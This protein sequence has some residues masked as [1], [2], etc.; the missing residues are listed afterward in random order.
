MAVFGSYI[1]R[2]RSLFGEAIVVSTLD[3]SV[4]LCAGLIIFPACAAYGVSAEAGP[5]LIFVS[6]PVMFNHMATGQLWG[7]LFFVFMLFAAMSTVVA[8]FENIIASMRDIYTDWS[9]QKACVVNGIGIFVLAIPCALG[10]SVW[11]NFAPLGEGTIVLD[12]EDF[13]L[14]NNLLPIG[15]TIYLM[16]CMHRYGWGWGN[17]IKEVDTGTGYKFPKSLRVFFSYIAPVIMLI[18][19][20]VGYYD[21]FF[22]KYIEE[23]KS[24]PAIVLVILAV[25]CA[26]LA[27]I[28]LSSKA[29]SSKETQKGR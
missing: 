26:L 25:A 23:G 20:I 5:G 13:I 6:L 29:A 3:T 9:R 4:A 2:D 1:N 10:F 24:I 15:S 11:S 27:Y 16:F 12:L 28:I 21:M 22:K 7:T 8:V 19:F 14:S 17:F 18:V